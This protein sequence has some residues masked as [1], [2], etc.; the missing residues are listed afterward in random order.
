MK[1]ALTNAVITNIGNI[2]N[3]LFSN[4]YNKIKEENESL[5]IYLNEKDNT[6]STLKNSVSFLTKNLDSLLNNSNNNANEKII[7]ECEQ[8]IKLLKEQMEQ[9]LNKINTE[10]N[11]NF[12]EKM[13]AMKSECDKL[14]KLLDCYNNESLIVVPAMLRKEIMKCAILKD[15]NS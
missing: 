5:K 14:S 10:K 13:N 1:K 8:K 2:Q 6:I 9:N 3:T 11:Q 7:T 12:E 15:E 4:D